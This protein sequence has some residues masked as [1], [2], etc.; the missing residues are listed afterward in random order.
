MKKNQKISSLPA[1][2]RLM[3]C[4]ASH[5]S[6]RP[7]PVSSQGYV[8]SITAKVS[9]NNQVTVTWKKSQKRYFVTVYTTNRRAANGTPLPTSTVPKYTHTSSKKYPLTAGKKYVYTVRAYKPFT[10][11]KWGLLRQKGSKL[12]QSRLSLARSTLPR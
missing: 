4:P 2:T 5:S 3:P 9:G 11:R 1:D 10:G 7:H 12:S 8:S 6:T